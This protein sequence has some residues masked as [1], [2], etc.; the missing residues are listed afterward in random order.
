[1]RKIINSAFVS[2]D[3]VTGHELSTQL[4]TLIEWQR[5][6]VTFVLAGSVPSATAETAARDVK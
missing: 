6:G 1:M 5:G 4:G 3:G 2:L